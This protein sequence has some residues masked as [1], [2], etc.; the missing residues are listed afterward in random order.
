MPTRPLTSEDLATLR[1]DR[2]LRGYDRRQID[3][4]LREL[5]VRHAD[6]A[7]ERDELRERLEAVEQ[8]LREYREVK[9]RVSD[10]LVRAEQTAD[11][12]HAEASQKAEQTFAEAHEHAEQELERG[13]REAAATVAA[14]RDEAALLRREVDRLQTVQAEMHAGYRAFLLSALE[15][16]DEHDQP[17]RDANVEPVDEL[18]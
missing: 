8:E 1:I 11:E 7:Q 4:L 2:R 17:P 3:R 12:V 13:R 9:A 6:L 15:L 5:A 10:A 18:R 16:L 14:A